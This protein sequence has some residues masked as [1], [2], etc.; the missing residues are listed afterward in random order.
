MHRCITGGYFL[1]LL[2]LY[3]FVAG[4]FLWLH[5]E[6]IHALVQPGELGPRN[7]HG[8]LDVEIEIEIA[9][10]EVDVGQLQKD[11]VCTVVVAD[12]TTFS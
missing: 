1:L 7:V 9:E 6:H 4:V 10:L 3:P 2:G 12:A 8:E 11:T 5:A